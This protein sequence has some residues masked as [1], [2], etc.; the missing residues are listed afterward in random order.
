M[1]D[2]IVLIH[3]SALLMSK[4]SEGDTHKLLESHGVIAEPGIACAWEAKTRVAA[5]ATRRDDM[6]AI[7][8]SFK[9]GSGC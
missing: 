5:A 9:G 8:D 6:A 7:A 4:M 2:A 1:N 3:G